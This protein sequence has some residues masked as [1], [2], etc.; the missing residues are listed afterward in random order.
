MNRV[1]LLQVRFNSMNAATLRKTLLPY[2]LIAPGLLFVALLLIYPLISGVSA[3]FFFQERLGGERA[4]VW[5]DN[6]RQL[7]SDDIFV[8]AFKNTIIYTVAVVVLQYILG[9]TLAL[10][11]NEE[12]RGRGLLRS[13]MLVPW[14]VPTIA[15]V[16]SWRFM[17]SEQFG[18]LNAALIKA[19]V[20]SR[21]IDWLGD[22]D[23]ALLSVIITAAWKTT[24]FVA[25]VMLAA[26]QAIERQMYESAVIDGAGSVQRFV[27]ITLPGIKA[28]STVVLL[29]TTIWT[30]NQFDVI[31]LMTKGG[32][33][34]A[35]Q[36]IPV[37]TYLNAF[38]FRRFNY[39]AAIATVGLLMMLTA[40]VF[41][42]R[43][44]ER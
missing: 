41:I 12:F 17:L 1:S 31:Y 29:L 38:S 13:L 25:V 27:Y 6:Y 19:G 9:L 23:V 24:P 36:T 16:L 34:N 43:R 10:F 32:P 8:P 21:G 14:I 11:L 7:L 26:L 5:F 4:F 2:L 42:Y 35:T 44:N 33:A 15:G 40:V 22:P 39:A 3:G 37:Y 28:V 20:L 18:I 30:F